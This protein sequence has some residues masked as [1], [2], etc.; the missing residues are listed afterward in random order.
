[1]N[2]LQVSRLCALA[3]DA[4]QES[5]SVAKRSNW[6]T[7][8][9]FFLFAL[10]AIASPAQSFTTLASFDGANGA[11]PYYGALVQGFDG[12]LYGTTDEGGT[13][14]APYGCG[15]VFRITPE[16]TLTTLY[17]FCAQ[18]GCPDGEEPYA[19]V[20]QATDGNFYGTTVY[21]G[22]HNSGTVF[23]ITPQGTL[24]RLYSFCARSNCSD[25]ANPIAGLV[26]AGDGNF[27]GTTA[28][29]GAHDSGTV[30]KITQAG[31]LTT[32]YSFCAQAGCPDGEKPFAGLVQASDRNFYGTTTYGGSKGWGT[33]FK[34][35]SLGTLTTLHSFCSETNCTDGWQGSGGLLQ[36]PDGNLY[37]I[38]VLGG[39]NCDPFGCGTVFKITLGGT[40]TTL[41]RFCAQAGCADGAFPAALFQATDGN[42]Y[43]TTHDG[44]T[45]P[46]C[47]G[48]AG[49]GTIFKI[50]PRGALK[51]LHSFCARTNCLDGSFP[52]AG[53]VQATD[54]NFY[55]TTFE[56]GTNGSGTVFSLSTGIG[57]F[58]ETLPTHGKVGSHV[59][60]RGTDLAG[61]T[62]VTFNGTP[63]T[64]SMLSSTLIKTTVPEGAT[65][66]KVQVTT[67][68][69]TLTSRVAF[70]VR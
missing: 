55:G 65:T 52:Q 11:L 54:G 42:F 18:S 38:T 62:A 12:N 3:P 66:G 41:Y 68:G 27:Y 43:G 2:I 49:C 8:C 46:S 28:A 40:L 64:F 51:T 5:G 7:A 69:G 4:S 59:A 14:C 24:T 70:R 48:G 15:T 45:H 67:P 39:A 16:G 53:L 44:G 9:A 61:A 32:I 26:R 29:G 34:I 23:K 57:P 13:N 17:S 56:G 30:F 21:G 22:D 36:A 25:G 10:A 35:T 47:N 33:V 20:V 58:V 6:K 31:T 19:G 63:A 50:T 1:M 37:G 60:I